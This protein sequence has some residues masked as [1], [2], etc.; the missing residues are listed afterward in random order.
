MS[1]ASICR[2]HGRPCSERPADLQ[3]LRVLLLMHSRGA[4][5]LL[6]PQSEKNPGLKCRPR[7]GPLSK[8]QR[9]EA[10]QWLGAQLAL[11]GGNAGLPAALISFAVWPGGQRRESLSLRSSSEAFQVPGVRRESLR[12]LPVC[13][14]TAAHVP[15]LAFAAGA[16]VRVGYHPSRSL[17][18]RSP[19]REGGLAQCGRSSVSDSVKEWF[20]ENRRGT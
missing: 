13:L 2:S 14:F 20:Q 16:R 7:E 19:C 9:S 5:V 11:R 8:P 12:T 10:A 17:V 18:A 15:P 6:G 4:L 1:D 3:Q